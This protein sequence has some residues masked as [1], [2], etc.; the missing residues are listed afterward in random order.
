MDSENE[1]GSAPIWVKLGRQ[2]NKLTEY[3]SNN[4]TNWIWVG[5]KSIT[6]ADTVH[7]GLIVMSDANNELFT[8]DNVTITE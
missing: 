1:G 7:V 6:M 8:A 5:S 3:R 4:G 2:G